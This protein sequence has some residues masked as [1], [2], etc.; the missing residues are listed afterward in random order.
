[1][2]WDFYKMSFDLVNSL[3]VFGRQLGVHSVRTTVVKS[4]YYKTFSFSH[5]A[6]PSHGGVG[7]AKTLSTDFWSLPPAN[8]FKLTRQ[9]WYWNGGRW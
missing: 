5:T 2:P 8:S 9:G 6:P 7:K 4:S 3:I 1:M